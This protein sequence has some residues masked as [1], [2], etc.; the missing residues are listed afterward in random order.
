MGFNLRNVTGKIETNCQV[1]LSTCFSNFEN[2]INAPKEELGGILLK[3]LI[4]IEKTPKRHDMD[5]IFLGSHCFKYHNPT[6]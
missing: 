3:C 5:R 2:L 1:E 4:E 6:L